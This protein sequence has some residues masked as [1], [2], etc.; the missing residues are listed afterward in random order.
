MAELRAAV[1]GGVNIVLVRK[2]GALWPDEHGLRV[3]AHPTQ[4][5]ISQLDEVVRTTLLSN[6]AVT[7]SDEY[8]AAFCDTL[9]DRLVSPEVAARARASA[10]KARP[11]A[12]GDSPAPSTPAHVTPLGGT[13]SGGLQPAA[14][15]SP[16]SGGGAL[17]RSGSH[18][19][20]GVAVTVLSGALT[21]KQ[22]RA[23]L[24]PVHTALTEVRRDLSELRREQAAAAAA[25]AAAVVP[26]RAAA[27]GAAQQALAALPVW[28]TA[29]GVACCAAAA[30]VA[31]QSVRAAPRA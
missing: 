19:T 12:A 11:A 17:Q 14:L 28:I 3:C 7:H 4:A 22:L 31:L 16:P 25:G 29:A 30:L 8:Y 21:E 27:D 23:E 24:Q 9:F 6:K 26:P 20:R 5:F 2:E 10:L 15:F 13:F 18:N 1:L